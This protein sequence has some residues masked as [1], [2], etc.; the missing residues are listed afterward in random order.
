MKSVDVIILNRNLRRVTERLADDLSSHKEISEVFVVDAGSSEIEVASGTFARDDSPEV[1]EHGLRLCRGFN[2]GLSKWVEQNRPTVEWVLL[3]PNDA[4]LVSADFSRF[5]S[6]AE[7]NEQMVAVVPVS[8]DNPYDSL[9]HA[10]GL[11]LAWLFYEGPILIRASYIRHRSS[12]G[13]RMFDSA[14]FRGYA[15]FLELAFQIYCSNLCMGVTNLIRFSENNEHL[16][17]E[18]NLIGTEPFSENLELL[19]RE[20]REWLSQKYGFTDRRNLENA[21]RL[22]F[23]EYIGKNPASGLSPTD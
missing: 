14:N 9:I 15:S 21:T 12:I 19:L 20:G 17:S 2:L 10:G 6:G 1:V 3:L 22:L 16:I 23:E 13:A 18:H 4:E 7:A 5:L 11:S 8:E